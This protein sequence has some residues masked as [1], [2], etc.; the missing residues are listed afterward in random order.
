MFFNISSLPLPPSPGG[1]AVTWTG[2]EVGGVGGFQHL[3]L[4]PPTASITW[5]YHSHLDWS[6]GGGGGD[7]NISPSSL[8]QPPSPGGITVTWTGVEVGGGGFQHLPLLPPTAS[9]TWWYRSHLDW[10][11]GGGGGGFQHLPLLPPTASITW[12][13]RSHLDWSGGGGGGGGIST[14]PPPPSHCLHH[15]VVSQS[16]G[17]EWRWGG[18]GISTSPPPPSHSLHHLVVSQSP[19]LEWRWGGGGFQHLPLLPPTASIT[20]WY[21]SHLPSWRWEGDSPH[22]NVSTLWFQ[23]V[24]QLEVGGGFSPHQ[25]L[26]TVVPTCQTAGGGRGILPTPMSPHCGSN[27]SDSWRWVGDSPHTNVSTLWFQPARLLV[28]RGQS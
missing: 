13:Y 1:I 6:G 25:C 2:V 21:R 3:P 20:W 12:W 22:T 19:G 18:G 10:S 24:R 14:S 28:L 7:F 5:W 8:P 9:I 23:P 11:G 17:L 4:L 26:H 16:P 27:L 15:L